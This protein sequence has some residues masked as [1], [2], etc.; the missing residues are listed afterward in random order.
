VGNTV[1]KEYLDE[2]PP[3]I[4]AGCEAPEMERLRRVGMNCGCEYTSFPLFRKLKTH[5]SR[6]DHSLG[7]A[8]LVWRFTGDPA[9]SLA[10]LFHD[11]ATPCFAHV[12]DFM[13]GDYMVQ[14]S[15]EEKTREIIVGSEAIRRL[16]REQGLSPDDVA[17]YHLYP[18]ADNDPPRLSADRLEYT[19]GN[20]LNFGRRGRDRLRFLLDDLTPGTAEDGNAELVFRTPACALDCG[21]GALEMGRIYVSDEDRFAMQTLAEL[22]RNAVCDGVITMDDLWMDEPFVIRKLQEAPVYAERWEHFRA[23]RTIVRG[24]PG[25]IVVHA[26]KRYIDPLVLGEGRLSAVSAPFVSDVRAF[27]DE[28]QEEPLSG[29]T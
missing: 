1:W 3:V 21:R 9:Q 6:F 18:V 24:R 28:S 2:I 15:T 16:L 4:R 7:A 23:F 20:L 19:L 25:G 5:Y 11:I 12:V 8:L 27:L 29:E 10:A 13:R 26:K 17:D 14:E 22:L